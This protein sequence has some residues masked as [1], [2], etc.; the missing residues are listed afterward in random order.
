MKDSITIRI[1]IMTCVQ[2]TV[3]NSDCALDIALLLSGMMAV[4]IYK[5]SHFDVDTC[6]HISYDRPMF[7]AIIQLL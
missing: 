1:N 7:S 2:F 5:S 3:A 4:N 6:R